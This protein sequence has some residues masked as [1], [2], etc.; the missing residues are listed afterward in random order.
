MYNFV[1]K[2]SSLIFSISDYF[3]FA[4]SNRKENINRPAFSVTCAGLLLP[5]AV[6]PVPNLISPGTERDE[7]LGRMPKSHILNTRNMY[8]PG[9]R[10]PHLA[11]HVHCILSLFWERVALGIRG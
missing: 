9:Q 2:T 7:A 1:Y 5:F 10:R 6:L 3:K 4:S 11:S 8:V